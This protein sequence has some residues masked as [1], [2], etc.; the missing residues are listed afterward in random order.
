MPEVLASS[1]GIDI[2]LCGNAIGTAKGKVCVYL[3][4]DLYEHLYLSGAGR[5]GATHRSRPNLITNLSLEM[6]G[7]SEGGYV[8]GVTRGS[9]LSNFSMEIQVKGKGLVRSRIVGKGHQEMG[10][11]PPRDRPSPSRVLTP[12]YTTKQ[13]SIL[14]ANSGSFIPEIGVPVLNDR[15]KINFDNQRKVEIEILKQYV[16]SDEYINDR[17]NWL[18][19]RVLFEGCPIMYLLNTGWQGITYPTRYI[20]DRN[21]YQY[22]IWYLWNLMEGDPGSI[23]P[24]AISG[25]MN[26]RTRTVQT[27]PTRLED[28]PKALREIIVQLGDNLEYHQG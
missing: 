18:L 27:V 25:M 17:V 14:L 28:L 11:V 26:D 5:V 6:E 16:T 12:I 1:N 20:L 22:M 24:G 4:L 8:K 10:I 2:F 3:D 9:G 19:A 23:G 15:S 7:N 13:L 21:R